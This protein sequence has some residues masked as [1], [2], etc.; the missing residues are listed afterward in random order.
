MS[1]ADGSIS[2]QA[3][4]LGVLP[5]GVRLPK[6]IEV[7]Q[8]GQIVLCGDTTAI[9]GTDAVGSGNNPSG[10]ATISL[11]PTSGAAPRQVHS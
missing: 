6:A 3:T 5:S 7:V 4:Q 10:S 11:H 8:K 2:G 9:P 1:G